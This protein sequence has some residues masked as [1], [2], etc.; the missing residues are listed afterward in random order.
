MQRPEA[1]TEPMNTPAPVPAPQAPEVGAEPARAPAAPAPVATPTAADPNFTSFGAKTHN[2]ITYRGVDWLM[3]ATF[4]VSFS[5]FA[6]RTKLGKIYSEKLQGAFGKVLSPILKDAK[7]LE[8]GSKWGARFANIMIGG[9][10]IIPFM[11]ALEDKKNKKSIIKSLDEM[12]YGKDAVAH[13]P[14]FEESYK[15]IDEEPPRDVSTGMVARFVALA[16]LLAITFTPATNN[17]MAK[18]IYNRIGGATKWTA[19]K[20][21]IRPKSLMARGEMVHPNGDPKLAKE[22]QSDW[23]YIHETIGFDFGLTFIYA[24]LHEGVINLLTGGKKSKAAPA[25]PAAAPALPI[26]ENQVASPEPAP[27]VAATPAPEAPSSKIQ[28]ADISR[29]PLMT[30]GLAPAHG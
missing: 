27:A 15:K 29:E 6:D 8:V 2:L 26:A 12:H 7:S 16:P 4:G 1:E 30:Q 28:P 5:Y 18:N 23:K 13:D 22:F 24:Y 19:E 14:K 10:A 3:N 21:G 11:A 25:Q 9:F 17:F 20:I